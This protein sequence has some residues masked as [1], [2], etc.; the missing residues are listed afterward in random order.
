MKDD[1]LLISSRDICGSVELTIEVTCKRCKQRTTLTFTPQESVD[2][3]GFCEQPH[4]Y[5]MDY[6]RLFGGP[7]IV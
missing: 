1:T 7:V 4:A 6:G 2:Y 3:C 5:H